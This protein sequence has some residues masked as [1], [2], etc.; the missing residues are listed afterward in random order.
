[1]QRLIAPVFLFALLVAGCR[2]GQYP[3][4]NEPDKNAMYDG[5]TLQENVRQVDEM[6][7]LRVENGKIDQSQKSAFL[8][9]Y[10]AEQLEGV[11]LDEI[12]TDQAWRFADVY[13]QMDDWQ[14]THDLYVVAVENASDED[15]R[16]NDT[17]RLAESVAMLGS[18]LEGI[19]LVRS[20]FDAEPTGKAPIL[21][22][23]LY[24]F[25]PAAL[26]SGHDLAVVKLL[27]EATEQ[28]L[29]TV[30]DPESESGRTFI[31]AR[32]YHVREAWR[33]IIPVYRAIGD[34]DVLRAVIA[35]SDR[36][37]LRFATI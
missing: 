25:V 19:D 4:P 6:L 28:H 21:M 35:R 15:R 13:R 12:P 2:F 34:I 14:A 11:D 16:V 24:E 29:L 27:E 36:V 30:V 10:I 26:G 22:A 17:L 33:A 23:T 9:E 1:M 31:K 3:N 7:A 37:M 5:E 8:L 18:V 20:T 32:F